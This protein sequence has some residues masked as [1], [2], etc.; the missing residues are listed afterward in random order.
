[1]DEVYRVRRQGSEE[2]LKIKCGFRKDMSRASETQT[3]QHLPL[4]LHP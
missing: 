3:A 1:M 2:K 4:K